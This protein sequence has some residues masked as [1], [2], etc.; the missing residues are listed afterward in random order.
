MNRASD[1]T[2]KL[3]HDTAQTVYSEVLKGSDPE[4]TIVTTAKAASYSKAW[5]SRLCEITNRLMAVDHI[6]RAKGDKAAS[7]HPLVDTERVL[8]RLFPTTV[9]GKKAAS[10]AQGSTLLP[11]AYRYSQISKPTEKAASITESPRGEGLCGFPTE[12]AVLDRADVLR[13]TLKVAQTIVGDRREAAL[14]ELAPLCKMAASAIRESGIN[15]TEIEER[16]VAWFGKDAHE[17]M[18]A[19]GSFAGGFTQFQGEPR[20]FTTNPWNKVPYSHVKAAV[21]ALRQNVLELDTRE[22]VMDIA[23]R[24]EAQLSQ[25]MRKAAGAK[26]GAGIIGTSLLLGMPERI[27]KATHP[28]KATGQDLSLAGITAEDIQFLN[29]IKAR[30]ALV[31]ALNHE[32]IERQDLG[33]VVRTYNRMGEGYGHTAMNETALISMLR[34]ALEQPDIGGTDIRQFQDVE[35][36][37]AQQQDVTTAA[38][39]S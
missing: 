14:V 36:G 32:G 8:T 23:R 7:E 27:S 39:R 3:L 25:G 20:V 33:D 38:G 6:D 18:R 30:Q 15:P 17:A 24:T 28:D 4:D 19:I 9:Q 37:L 26:E 31:G 13:Q 16:A 22:R 35:K 29:S 2:L 5:T 12:Q 11:R 1:K 34:Q 10:V 21:I